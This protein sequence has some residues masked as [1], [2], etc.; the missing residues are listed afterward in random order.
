[1]KILAGLGRASPHLALTPQRKEASPH[2]QRATHSHVHLDRFAKDE[3]PDA[4]DKE[5]GCTA[6]A[7]ATS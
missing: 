1:M 7:S 3:N 6:L 2:H 5:K 4:R